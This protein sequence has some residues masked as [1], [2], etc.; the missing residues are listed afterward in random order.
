MHEKWAW[1]WVVRRDGWMRRIPLALPLFREFVMNESL[2]I[3]I[4][5]RMV[6]SETGLPPVSCKQIFQRRFV[7]QTVKE[8]GENALPWADPHFYKEV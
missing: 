8:I 3:A 7:L 1:V 2:G 4:Q 6:E 5:N